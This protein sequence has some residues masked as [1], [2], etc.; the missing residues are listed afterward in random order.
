MC[1][2]IC[3]CMCGVCLCMY[4]YVCVCMY[5]VGYISIIDYVI[6]MEMYPIYI[7]TYTLHTCYIHIAT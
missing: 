5:Y 2:C 3:V 7:D 1:M 4:L 6:L